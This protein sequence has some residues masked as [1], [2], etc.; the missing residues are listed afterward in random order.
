ML[1]SQARIS[2]NNHATAQAVPIS[3]TSLAQAYLQRIELSADRPVYYLKKEGKYQPFLWRQL[4]D[5]LLALADYY[6]TIGLAPGDRVCIMSQSCPEWNISDITNLCLGIITVPIY[7]SSSPEDTAYIL[8]HC[9]PKLVFVEN[10]TQ[11]SNAKQSLAQFKKSP[12]M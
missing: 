7:H 5:R 8:Q 12:P 1:Q 4:N 6:Q 3:G 10:S 11:L 9:D 2:N